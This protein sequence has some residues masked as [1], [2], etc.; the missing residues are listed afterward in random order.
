M[1]KLCFVPLSTHK[2]FQLNDERTNLLGGIYSKLLVYT[3]HRRSIMANIVMFIHFVRALDP[4]LCRRVI[5]FL[6]LE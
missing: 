1:G 6:A 2:L 4:I 5:Q 3:V